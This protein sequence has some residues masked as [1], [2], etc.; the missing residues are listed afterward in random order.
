VA[1]VRLQSCTVP[2]CWKCANMV[3]KVYL[4]SCSVPTCCLLLEVCK[5]GGEGPPAVLLCGAHLRELGECLQQVQVG[6]RAVCVWELNL[7]ISFIMIYFEIFKSIL[8]TVST[9]VA[10]LDPV[11]SGPFWSDPDQDVLDRIWI[12]ALIN[13]P[14]STFCCVEKPQIL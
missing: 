5:H 8:H 1:R 11:K 4:Q 3:A 12:L 13:H 10:D 9:S 2:T 14:K 7:W 6:V